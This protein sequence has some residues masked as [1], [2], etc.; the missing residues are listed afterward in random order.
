MLSVDAVQTCVPKPCGL[1]IGAP[2]ERP[3]KKKLMSL[4]MVSSAPMIDSR[5]RK[6]WLIA[7]NKMR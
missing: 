5:V 4:N 1:I 7:F 6:P 2:T 3:S